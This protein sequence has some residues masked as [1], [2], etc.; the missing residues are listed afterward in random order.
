MEGRIAAAWLCLA[1]LA[2]LTFSTAL[3]ISS[4]VAASELAPSYHAPI[5]INGNAGLIAA[6]GVVAGNGSAD[7]PYLI[8]GWSIN[9]TGSS[10]ILVEDTTA[11]LTIR[12]VD[13]QGPVLLSNVTHA[14]IENSTI[15]QGAITVAASSDV[16][17]RGNALDNGS[18]VLSTAF[19]GAYPPERGSHGIVVD[20]NTV[21]LSPWAGIDVGLD[22]VT[23]SRNTVSLGRTGITIESDNVAVLDNEIAMDSEGIQ[24]DH[25]RNVTLEGNYLHAYQQGVFALFPDNLTMVDNVLSCGDHW[26]GCPDARSFYSINATN[27]LAFHNRFLTVQETARDQDGVRSRWDDGYPGGGNYWVNYTGRDYC[28]GVNQTDCTLGDGLGDTPYRIDGGASVDRYPLQL[29]PV[30]DSPVVESTPPASATEGQ[31]CTFEARVT[32]SGGIHN[33]TLY[34]TD[35]YSSDYHV[36]PM[37]RGSD[38]VYRATVVPAAGASWLR[39]YIVATDEIGN[40]G[41]FPTYTW[42]GEDQLVLV[43]NPTAW[44][45]SAAFFASVGAVCVGLVLLLRSRRPRA[46]TLLP[47]PSGSGPPQG[48]EGSEGYRGGP[49]PSR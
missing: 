18:I 1:L 21:R 32:D 37:V 44:M 49:P 26:L 9:A 30:S 2:G 34:F 24:I 36:V 23:V 20:A 41:T 3:P 15:T 42:F 22:N 35:G 27:L 38:G 17:V 7:D 10:A 5:Q 43:N 33:V 19:S 25:G 14:H 31:P 13:V 48:P 8:W 16:V 45:L 12:E 4:R 47:P 29:E 11:Y 6:N 40:T 28:R 39:Y 46:P